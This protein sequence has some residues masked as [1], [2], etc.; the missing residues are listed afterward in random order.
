VQLVCGSTAALRQCCDNWKDH[1]LMMLS[2][3][4]MQSVMPDSLVEQKASIC[5]ELLTFATYA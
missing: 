4:V 2:M 1:E 3:D 5:C